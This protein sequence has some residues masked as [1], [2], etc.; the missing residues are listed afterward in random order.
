MTR[1]GPFDEPRIFGKSVPKR[2][3]YPWEHPDYD[4]PNFLKDNI[5]GYYLTRVFDPSLEF[6]YGN[7]SG[8]DFK[9]NGKTYSI[10]FS[11]L[12]KD[13]TSWHF[14]FGQS[15]AKSILFFGFRDKVKPK[16][17]FC[18]DL[19]MEKFRDRNR[20]NIPDDEYCIKGYKEFGID[21][22]KLRKMQE[23]L[24]AIENRDGSKMEE[25]FPNLYNLDS[26]I[27]DANPDS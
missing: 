18:L 14:L 4:S 16:L 15:K 10:R 19:P 11:C 22:E 24:T 5:C 20:I 21:P 17:E 27:E 2:R 25:I 7:K 26:E 6:S 13:N 1:P 8:Y 3:K 9:S 12:A 23:V